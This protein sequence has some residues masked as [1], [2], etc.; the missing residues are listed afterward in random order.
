[1]ALFGILMSV[2]ISVCIF[3]STFSCAAADAPPEKAAKPVVII[4]AQAWLAETSARLAPNESNLL[5]RTQTILLGNIVRSEAWNSDRAIV[6]STTTYR[7]IWNWDSAFHAI[8][9]SNWDPLL[10]REQ[11]NIIF[12]RQLSNGALPDVIWEHGGVV[13]NCTKP[14]VMAWAVAVIDHRWPD[15][16][17]LKTMYPKLIRLGDFWMNERGGKADG[18]FY[19]AGADIGYDSGWDDSVR[20]D[21]GYRTAKGNDHRLWAVDL[22]C[23]MVM[24]YRAMA[25]IAGRLQR[26]EEE[27]QWLEQ[28]NKLARRINETLWDEKVHFYVDRDRLTGKAGPALSPAGFMPLFLHIAPLNRAELTAKIACDTRKFFPG[29]PTAAYD[30]PGYNEHAMWRG[31]TWLN[32]SFFALKGL[33]DYGDSEPADSMRTILLGWVTSD[34]STIWERYDA[35]TGHGIGAKG[36]GW[37]A[38]FC[39]AFLLDWDNNHL[40]WLFP[41]V[42]KS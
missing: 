16:G 2:V 27:K 22:N 3:I 14:P 31:N 35:Q 10:A 34:S 8:A 19:Y 17:Y 29:M 5:A 28:A 26:I 18:L 25:Y 38:G 36:F 20:W 24:H 12:S 9:V 42:P 11:I 15:I 30:T 32:T 40:T 39:M 33:H 23:Y 21:D 13:T 7:G 1:M 41:P 6:P 4:P 37:S